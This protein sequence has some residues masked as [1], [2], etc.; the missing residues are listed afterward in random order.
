ML[1]KNKRKAGTNNAIPAVPAHDSTIEQIITNIDDYLFD[2]NDPLP[3]E[4]II[5]T[6][7][8]K[9]IL[10]EKN[11]AI[12]SGKPKSRKSV[13]AH[14]LIAS[15]LTNKPVLGIETHTDKKIVLIDTEQSKHDLKRSLMRMC[16]LADLN[17]IPDR[18]KIYSVRQLSVIQIQK[19]LTDIAGNPENG[20]IIIDGGLD[21]IN[22][23]NDVD[24]S[25]QVIHLIK[26]ILVKQAIGIVMIIHQSKSTNFTIGHFGSYFDRFAQSV[27]D[28]AKQDDGSSK[29]SSA[30]MR[31]DADFQPY[32][33]Y[34]NF[35]TNNYCIDWREQE[36]IL[37]RFPSD[38]AMDQ[39]CKIL[40]RI[41]TEIPEHTYKS[42][43]DACKTEYQK[44]EH[45]CKTLIKHF[46]DHELILKNDSKIV[47]NDVVL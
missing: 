26:Q 19:M 27:I 15:G 35:N 1:A 11:V 3:D 25:K 47:L 10:T 2:A 28:V 40:K 16:S 37:A 6:I 31:S 21:I 41:F 29:I 9:S 36:T 7:Q 5:I 34:W 33:F 14:S 32:Q 18:L 13:V 4:K 45:W 39:H 43:T 22:N 12:I 46:Y 24:E 23:M 17:K 38:I 42:L 20:L 44:S 30:M 8:G